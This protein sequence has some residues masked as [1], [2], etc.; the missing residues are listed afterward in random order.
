MAIVYQHRRLDTNE[1]FY[2][3]I[4][5][6]EKRAY[7]F[8]G[9]NPIW[10][11]IVEK[12]GYKVEIIHNKI[13]RESACELEMFYIQKYGRKDLKTGILCNLTDGGEGLSNLSPEIKK[14]H[15]LKV[16]KTRIE[17]GIAKGENNPMYG[18]KGQLS[19]HYGKK[20]PEHSLVMK[21]KLKPE[22]F[23]EKCR[24]NKTGEKN[25]QSK[26]KECDVIWVKNNFIKH[27]IEYGLT[28]I[29]KKYNVSIAT[30]SNI[31]NNKKWKHL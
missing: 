10:K 17:K 15:S 29:S 27:H 11:N 20:R 14:E 7:S 1:I 13:S 26:L 25:L 21:G 18:K 6:E 30:I 8:Y 5:K 16:S 2:I 12:V 3:G 31:V 24:I 9:R 22:G 28:P 23:S 4:G 19:P